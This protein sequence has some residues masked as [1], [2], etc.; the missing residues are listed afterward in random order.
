MKPLFE[1]PQGVNTI[2][3]L[4]MRTII[5]GCLSIF[6]LGVGHAQAAVEIKNCDTITSTPDRMRCLQAN[7]VILKGAIEDLQKQLANIPKPPPFPSLVGYVKYED[8]LT[9]RQPNSDPGRAENCLA[10]GAP[11]VLQSCGV[12]VDPPPSSARWKLFPVKPG[13]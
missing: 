4:P 10:S 8:V 1:Q 11:T 12:G 3:G 9:V 6:A 13:Q 2:G 5:V 7:E